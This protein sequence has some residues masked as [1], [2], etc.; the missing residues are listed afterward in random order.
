MLIF[1]LFQKVV[2]QFCSVFK[3]RGARKSPHEKKSLVHVHREYS[4]LPFDWLTMNFY[5]FHRE[6]FFAK[7]NFLGLLDEET[8]DDWI[9]KEGGC[10]LVLEVGETLFKSWWRMND[11]V[12]S[13]LLLPKE[14]KRRRA[15]FGLKQPFGFLFLALSERAFLFAIEWFQQKEALFVMDHHAIHLFLGISFINQTLIGS[16][17]IEIW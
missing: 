9:L 15:F 1:L 6:F 2:I 7:E 11:N 8:V 4:S 5:A 12:V 10:F 16:K 17:C 14:W 3:H 13:P